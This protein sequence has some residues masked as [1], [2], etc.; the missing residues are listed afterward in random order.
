MK[1]FHSKHRLRAFARFCSNNGSLLFLVFLVLCGAVLGCSAFSMLPT[2]DQSFLSSILSSPSNVSDVSSGC[3]A[4]LSAVFGNGILLFLLFLFGLTAFGGPL[5]VLTELFYGFCI[6]TAESQAFYQGGFIATAV[7]VVIPM[8]LSGIAL[9]ISGCQSMQMSC[10]FT[11]QLLPSGAHCGGMW[12]PFRNYLLRFMC[13]M[14]IA[15]GAAV[16][17]VLAHALYQV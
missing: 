10:T 9:V 4:V 2:E 15:L 8:T 1:H 13:C 12:H 7:H 6:G 5:I 16:V 14:L 11:K 17:Q 3:T